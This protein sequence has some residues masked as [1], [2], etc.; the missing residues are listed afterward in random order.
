MKILILLLRNHDNA[1]DGPY[2]HVYKRKGTN[3]ESSRGGA[4]TS[5]ADGNLGVVRAIEGIGR[6]RRICIRR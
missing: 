6:E 5:R 2:K 1:I 3:G 4:V